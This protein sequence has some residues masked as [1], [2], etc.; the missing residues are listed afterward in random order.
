[1]RLPADAVFAEPVDAIGDPDACAGAGRPRAFHD[2]EVTELAVMAHQP[3]P[4]YHVGVHAAAARSRR[5]L[6]E[7]E[8]RVPG[9][10]EVTV[11]PRSHHVDH[12][13]T[14]AEA[15]RDLITDGG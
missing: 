4:Q 12:F 14:D 8:G 15:S 7:V 6:Q 3:A 5:T 9:D 10:E 1:M 13:R 11:P 2:C